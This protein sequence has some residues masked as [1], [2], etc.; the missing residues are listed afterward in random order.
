LKAV[1]R[2]VLLDPEARDCCNNN[3]TEFAGSLK[4][5]F[6]R[7]MN[8]IKG[9]NLSAP[10]GIYRNSMRRA[11]DKMGQLPMYSPS[12]FNF[13]S[14]DYTPDGPMKGTGKFG[15]EFQ[16]LNSQTLTGYI[17]AL[18]TWVI[19]D[20]PLEYYP[21]F[22][23]ETYKPNQEPK[24]DLTADNSLARND[25]LSQLLDKYNLILA[26]GRL[27]EQSLNIIQKA[28][29]GMPLGLTNGVPNS[30]DAARRVRIA[31]YLI[32]TSPDYLINK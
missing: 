24:F 10:G 7:Y 20:Y 11:Y 27:S 13:F 9:L 32:M 31:I 12:V 3:N 5:P 4:E 19:S 8:L 2:A 18:N 15:P 17:N 22:N 25:R 30:D 23:N 26:H 28:L 14:P 21:Y 16:T 29:V 1:I 6:L